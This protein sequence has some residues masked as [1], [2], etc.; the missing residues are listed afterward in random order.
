M[1]TLEPWYDMATETLACSAE[2]DGYL[3]IHCHKDGDDRWQITRKGRAFINVAE[4][5]P[6]ML[7]RTMTYLI[8]KAR[9]V[10]FK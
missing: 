9:L 2:Q 8:R 1:S 4:P 6:S 3:T 10:F 5:P 7:S